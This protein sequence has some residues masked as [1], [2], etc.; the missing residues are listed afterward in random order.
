MKKLDLYAK[1]LLRISVI[2]ALIYTI[3]ISHWVGT[4]GGL[5]IFFIT[6]LVDYINY[7]FFKID[8]IITATS[9]LYCILSLVMGSMLDFY[10]KIEWWDLLMHILS[11]IILGIIA[12]VILIKNTGKFKIKKSF[13]FLFIVGIACIGGVVWEIFEFRVDLLFKLDTQLANGSGISDT[14]WDLIMDFTGGVGA[15]I[16]FIVSKKENKIISKK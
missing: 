11:G 5:I 10:D 16:Y 12:N 15:A 7:K 4:A 14:M 9:Y 1:W 13:R 6:F 8:S 2:G 3:L